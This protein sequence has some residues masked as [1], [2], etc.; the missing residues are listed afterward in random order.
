[1]PNLRRRFR[2]DGPAGDGV[3][4]GLF[5]SPDVGD[6]WLSV[7]LAVAVLL[8]VFVLLPLLGVAL[9][10]IVLLFVLWSGIVGRLILGR[11]WIVEAAPLDGSAEPVAVPVKGWRRSG[12]TATQLAREI[13]ATGRPDHFVEPEAV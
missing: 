5:I 3:I 12:E 13:E 1:M 10:L 8:I 11:P 6:S 2:R 7:G 9:E 4:E